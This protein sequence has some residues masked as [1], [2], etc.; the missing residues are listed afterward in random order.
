MYSTAI[1]DIQI[2][3]TLY[4]GPFPL[5][6]VFFVLGILLAENKREYKLVHIIIGVFATLVMQIIESKWLLS[7][8]LNG[9]GFGIKP[10]SFLFSII[11]ILLLFSKRFENAFS[12]NKIINKAIV[13]VGK[14]SFVVYLSHTLMLLFVSRLSIWDNFTW[15]IRFLLLTI[16]DVAFVALLF[17]CSPT[18]MRRY[19]GF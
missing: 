11:T 10:S 1:K 18:R 13:F 6:I 5:W 14:L 19:I 2:P 7:Q 15:G 12:S 9:I 4:A 8:S 3:L 16:I 17:Q